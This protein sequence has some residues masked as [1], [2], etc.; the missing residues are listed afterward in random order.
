MWIYLTPIITSF[1]STISSLTH[2]IYS[3]ISYLRTR[4][5]KFMKLVNG[6]RDHGHPLHRSIYYASRLVYKRRQLDHY[7]SSSSLREKNYL[8]T[9]VVVGGT[10]QLVL[11]KLRTGPKP[12]LEYAYFDGVRKDHFFNLISGPNRD[13]SGNTDVLFLFGKEI[14]YKYLSQP[15]ICIRSEIGENDRTHQIHELEKKILSMTL[16][17]D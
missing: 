6:Y 9:K 2:G 8:F 4:F 14:R 7:A 5:N 16:S 10:M 3:H 11:T 15:E 12:M 17:Y 13:F 1:T